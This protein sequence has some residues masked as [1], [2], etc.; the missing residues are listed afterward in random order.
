MIISTKLGHSLFWSTP[1]WLQLLP[2]N[3]RSRLSQK[4]SSTV[5]QCFTNTMAQWFTTPGRDLTRCII[6]SLSIQKPVSHMSSQS[7]QPKVKRWD[8]SKKKN[9]ILMCD[10][11]GFGV[12]LTKSVTDNMRVTEYSGVNLRGYR[13]LSWFMTWKT[14]ENGNLLMCLRL[15]FTQSTS[16]SP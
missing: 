4:H 15:K 7:G 8:H 14:T 13:C 16:K 9:M 11:L 12:P 3:A 6:C 2:H 10:T 1:T 5:S